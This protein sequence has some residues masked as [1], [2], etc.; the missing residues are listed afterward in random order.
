M[1]RSELVAL[2]VGDVSESEDGLDVATIRIG[3]TDHAGD[4]A[5]CYREHETMRALKRWLA[6]VGISSDPLFRSLRK[7][8][9]VADRPLEAGEVRSTLRRLADRANLEP[10]RLERAFGHSLRVGMAP[11]LI[12]SGADLPG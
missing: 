7:D 5:E 10:A 12:A 6:G 2:Q 4:G 11:D 1:S 3:K 9:R 8:G